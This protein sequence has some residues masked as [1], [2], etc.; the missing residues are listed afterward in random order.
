MT[1]IND[2]T[3]RALKRIR[4]VAA[5]EAPSAADSADTLV[6]LNGIMNSG[7]MHGFPTTW[8]T[9]ELTDTFPLDARHER[10]VVAMLAVNI[11][12]MFGKPIDADL[13][14][15]AME[16]QRTLQNDFSIIED[17]TTDEALINMPSRRRTYG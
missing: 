9:K 13:A 3:T 8:T 10:G 5:E 16:G 14:N 11:A 17:M 1:T 7:D 6:A 4:V 2:I 15:E 12:G